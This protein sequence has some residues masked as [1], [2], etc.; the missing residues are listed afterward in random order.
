MFMVYSVIEA[1]DFYDQD[2]AKVL[3]VFAT[4]SEAVSY[5]V[6]YWEQDQEQPCR[7]NKD[8]SILDYG[9]RELIPGDQ[10]RVVPIDGGFN[11]DL[12]DPA[13]GVDVLQAGQELGVC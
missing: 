6:G 4:Y 1:R 8:G 10:I 3:G 12:T 2:Q 13:V 9:N 5:G 7:Y 11:E